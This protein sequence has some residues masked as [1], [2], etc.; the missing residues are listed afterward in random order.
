MPCIDPFFLIFQFIK[1]KSL[2]TCF[3]DYF[4][5]HA[6]TWSYEGDDGEL[7]LYMKISNLSQSIHPSISLS[8]SITLFLDPSNV[9][10]LTYIPRRKVRFVGLIDL[11]QN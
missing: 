2:T 7:S 6:S 8:P 4:S 9:L 11:I 1:R 10:S 5:E 3:C